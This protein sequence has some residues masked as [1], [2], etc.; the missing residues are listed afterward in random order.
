LRVLEAL[1]YTRLG[2]V[3]RHIRLQIEHT[4]RLILFGVPLRLQLHR[5]RIG[6]HVIGTRALSKLL[7]INNGL[8]EFNQSLKNLFYGLE[9]FPKRV[10][11]FFKLKG[12]GTQTLSQ[13]LIALDSR[14]YPLITSLT[15]EA[16]ELDA[17]QEQQTMK[18]T[19][20][21]ASCDYYHSFSLSFNKFFRLV[22]DL[23]TDIVPLRLPTPNCFTPLC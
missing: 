9:N 4:L 12:I 8:D 10:D 22:S 20:E 17:Q 6:L 11:D 2:V 14:K 19:L 23:T 3:D 16:L 1:Y 7:Y 18:L 21:L 15:K 5:V 13:F